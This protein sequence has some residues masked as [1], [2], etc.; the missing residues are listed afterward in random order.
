MRTQKGERMGVDDF[1]GGGFADGMYDEEG[2]GS[3][4]DDDNSGEDDDNES[5]RDIEDL[6]DQEEDHAQDLAKLAKKDPEFFKYLQE[7]DR[8]L[9]DFGNGDDDED[10]DEEEEEEEE[11]ASEIQKGKKKATDKDAEVVTSAMLKG[12]QKS[13]LQVG[14]VVHSLAES[15]F[16]LTK[17]LLTARR[18]TLLKPFGGCCLLFGQQLTWETET[19]MAQ[20][21]P[22]WSTMLLSSTS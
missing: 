13:I 2:N 11:A 8:E 21:R 20:N 18:H 5:L 9:L 4:D 16:V 22:T 10:V 19:R 17:L 14:N 7:N 3:D 1:M 12:W 15:T 6:S